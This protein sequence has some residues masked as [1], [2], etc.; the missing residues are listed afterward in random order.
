VHL[1]EILPGEAIADVGRYNR[2][3]DTSRQAIIRGRTYE[4]L[5]TAVLIASRGSIPVRVFQSWS[6]LLWPPNQR[7]T[8]VVVERHEVGE[9]YNAGIALILEQCRDWRYLLTL[10]ED[11][12]PPRDAVLR[13]YESIRE[14]DIVGGLYWMKH[15]C[16]T[17]VAFGD[18]RASTFHLRP[19]LPQPDTVMPVCMVGLGCTLWRLE[20]FRRL[21]GPWFETKAEVSSE[22]VALTQTQD[23]CFFERAWQ[24]KLRV[25]VDTRVRVGHLDVAPGVIY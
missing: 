12:L 23:V 25:A 11:N 15:E 7:R 22:G 21:P 5:S 6:G 8:Q 3:F 14:W 16:P 10:E 13:L 1:D 20:V 18:P 24:A 9:A 17:P 2:D 19:I 4:D